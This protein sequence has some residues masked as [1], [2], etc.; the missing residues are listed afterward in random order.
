M[1][2]TIKG[3]VQ[4]LHRVRR[5]KGQIEAVER[6]LEAESDCAEILQRVAAARGALNS[7][8]AEVLEGHLRQ[9]ILA[10]AGVRFAKRKQFAED[11][12][13]VVRAYLR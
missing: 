3:K 2:H 4:L 13:G 10:P 1:S 6:A 9:H 7:L 12:I 8:M 11:L 5:I